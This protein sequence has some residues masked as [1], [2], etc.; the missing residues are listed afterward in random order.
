MKKLFGQ[1]CFRFLKSDIKVTQCYIYSWRHTCA[2]REHSFQLPFLPIGTTM[3]TLIHILREIFYTC[4]T[5]TCTLNATQQCS[6]SHKWSQ[7]WTSAPWLLVSIMCFMLVHSDN[8]PQ[9]CSESQ[10]V[11]IQ[12]TY[13]VTLIVYCQILSPKATYIPLLLTT[14]VLRDVVLPSEDIKWLSNFNLHSSQ[15][16]WAWKSLHFYEPCRFPL[17]ENCM[18]VFDAFCYTE[19]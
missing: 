6:V 7:A 11:R 13:I 3:L 8:I 18:L 1:I 15:Y 5:G 4:I 2:P 9:V 17:L 14:R 12:C 10:T 19:I 16:R